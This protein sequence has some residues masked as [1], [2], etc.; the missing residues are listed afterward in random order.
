MVLKGPAPVV[1]TPHWNVW[2]AGFGG[3]N[4]ISGDASLGSHTT[5]T[6]TGA[7]A[8]GA[9]DYV[10]SDTMF[11]LALAGGGTAWSLADAL[12]GGRSNVFQAGVYGVHA[13]G[14]A[15]VAGAFQFGNYW[16]TTNRD[17]TLVGGGTLQSKFAAQ[18]YGGRVEG[19]Y[20]IPL[21]AVTFTPYGAVQPQ[22]F[23]TPG[24]GE[25]ATSGSS[26]FAL[27]YNAQ[28][29]TEVRGEIGSWANKTL[30]LSNGDVLNVFGRAAYAHDWQTNP[31]LT[32]G[33]L[34]LPAASFVVNGAEP[35]A[36]L[37]L[38]TAGAELRLSANWSLMAKFEGEFA[39]GYESYAGT[40]R[41]T[42]TW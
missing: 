24:F 9:D 31:S 14:P 32:A 4:S 28:T 35:P 1:Y 33:F 13:F 5:S 39:G 8:I 19:G 17:V 20:H 25:Y 15:Y 22:A 7:F 34:S 2:G 21:E 12:G 40:G 16:V 18:G 10:T 37:A 23:V 26:A 42:Y 30:V 6:G 27:S 11:G 36:N 41:I 29:G 3:A 38:V